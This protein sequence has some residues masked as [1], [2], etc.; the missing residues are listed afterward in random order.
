MHYIEE[1]FA[2]TRSC[3]DLYVGLH[4]CRLPFDGRI[5]IHQA[6]YLRRI[7]EHF[8]FGD[9]SPFSTPS[10]LNT[11]LDHTSEPFQPSFP[12]SVAVGCLL[13]AQ[14]LSHPDISYV[15]STVAQFSANPQRSHY[16]A[17]MRIFR[18]LAGTLDLALCF[19]NH[20]GPLVLEGYG[21]ADYAGDITD[22]KSRTSTVLLL[23][24]APISWCSG[25]QNCV[26]T[27]T[28]KSEYIAAGSTTK[29]IIWH[30]RLLSNLRFEQSKAT[31]LFSDNQSAIRLV[32][33]PE[34]HSRTKHID[35]T[36]HFLREHHRLGNINIQYI[37]TSDQLADLFTKDL[38]ANRFSLF[39]SAIGLLS[40][41]AALINT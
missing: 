24:G 18:Y 1:H 29:D 17:V 14:T 31:R 25:K 27:S 26:A 8:G 22:R 19:G 9:C 33:N 37:R 6:I 41:P 16:Q 39:R 7:L 40:L 20:D 23:N 21:D 36:H 35:I 38:P 5:F 10:D 32:H 28:T 12:Y 34:F 13:F 3:A 30:R 11:K 15:V 4:I 2:I